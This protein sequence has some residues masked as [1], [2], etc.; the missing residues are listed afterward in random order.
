M[1]QIQEL[2]TEL[3][4]LEREFA[5]LPPERK[6]RLTIPAI[7]HRAYDEL[8]ITEYLEYILDP[9]SNGIG[10][11]PILMMLALA[12]NTTEVEAIIDPSSVII[13]R[14]YTFSSIPNRRIDLL[15]QANGIILA[16]ENKIGTG[17]SESQTI[18]YAKGISQDFPDLDYYLIFLTPKGDI[19]SSCKF[20]A[21]SY[22]DML[23][24]F[25]RIPFSPLIDI[26][27]AVIWEDFLCHLEDYIIMDAKKLLLGSKTNLYI[28]H[29]ETISV[30][31]KEFEEDA[32]RVFDMAISIIKPHFANDWEPYIRQST[33][34]QYFIHPDWHFNE[35]YYVYFEFYFTPE[36]IISS[37]QF[38]CFLGVAPAYRAGREFIQLLKEQY[39][40]EI[41]QICMD[42]Q[43]EPFQNHPEKGSGLL[44]GYKEYN[45]SMDDIE[46]FQTSFCQA[47]EEFKILFPIINKAVNEFKTKG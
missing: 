39:N 7:F 14:E 8:F 4:F 36:S 13:T 43:I 32:S 1:D 5:T 18:D 47:I 16:I 46:A 35:R 9:R 6:R 22:S 33:P 38:S 25:R 34:Y 27:K 40:D 3:F 17:E 10:V 12:E 37:K 42:R 23:S 20:K 21:V 28:K 44:V 11:A 2:E 31:R 15:L 26:H 29:L 19:P 41:V 24:A 30:L 45:V